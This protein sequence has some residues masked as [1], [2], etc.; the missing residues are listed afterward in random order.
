MINLSSLSALIRALRDTSG[1]VDGPLAQVARVASVAPVAKDDAGA[2]TSTALR[3]SLWARVQPA[4]PELLA[5]DAEPREAVLRREASIDSARALPPSPASGLPPSAPA[6]SVDE[7][8]SMALDF[9][10]AARLLQ[11]ALRGT[12]LK[13]PVPPTIT[14]P[15][16]L[17]T[18]SRASAPE[19]ALGLASAVAESGLFYESH[20]ARALRRDY[21]IAALSREPQAAWPASSVAQGLA[22]SIPASALPEASSTL[23]TKQ[24][25]VIDT[26]AVVWIGEVWP[27]QRATVT[28]E[29]ERGREAAN[30]ADDVRSPGP[31]RTR[32]TLD[33]P[34]LG[35]VQATLDL[36]AGAVD[37]ALA[38]TS[39]DSQVRLMS[40]KSELAGSLADAQVAVGRFD[41]GLSPE[42]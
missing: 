31:W 28:F 4:S 33:L 42:E 16:P 26:R 17:V 15:T 2:M 37:L 18:S 38:A 1:G 41:V 23:L 29:E 22:M 34:S 6:V 3:P 36:H 25:D 9:T 24:L 13:S 32:I 10:A 39:E 11:A 27:G 19:L 21:P 12:E 5:A 40:A 30:D 7:S 20:L 8:E 35:R 14:S